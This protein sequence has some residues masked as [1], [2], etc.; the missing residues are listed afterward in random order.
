M[1]QRVGKRWTG[2]AGPKVMAA[3]GGRLCRRVVF[4]DA[5]GA[6]KRGQKVHKVQRVQRVQRV[7]YRPSGDEFYIPLR[8]KRYGIYF[9][10]SK[11]A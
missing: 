1:V 2:P 3:C 9:C 8:G 7:W 6:W 5:Q 4:A 11:A 10:V